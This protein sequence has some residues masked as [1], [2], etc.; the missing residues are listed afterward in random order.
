MDYKHLVLGEEP[1]YNAAG[2]QLHTLGMSDSRSANQ[3]TEP[4]GCSV[5]DIIRKHRRPGRIQAAFRFE[6]NF[7][8]RAIVRICIE[9]TQ[10]AVRCSKIEDRHMRRGYESIDTQNDTCHH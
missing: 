5:A 7:P 1:A 6:I 4:L 9:K 8:S 2:L 3:V 10:R